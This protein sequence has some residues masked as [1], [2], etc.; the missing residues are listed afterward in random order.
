MALVRTHDGREVVTEFTC[1]TEGCEEPVVT[2]KG[3]TAGYCTVL[4]ENGKTHRQEYLEKRKALG[5]PGPGAKKADATRPEPA[6]VHGQAE[7]FSWLGDVRERIDAALNEVENAETDLATAKQRL[8][9]FLAE[10]QD[11]LK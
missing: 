1:L 2:H 6:K 8:R 10:A 4:Q 9:E 5:H 7:G 11:A 3:G